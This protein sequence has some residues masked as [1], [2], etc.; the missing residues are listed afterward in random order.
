VRVC[1]H[2]YYKRKA[3]KWNIWGIPIIKYQKED[4]RCKISTSCV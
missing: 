2:I 3:M 4:M 1:N